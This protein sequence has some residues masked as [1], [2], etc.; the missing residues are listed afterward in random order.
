[1]QYILQAIYAL[2]WWL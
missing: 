1:L 2:I